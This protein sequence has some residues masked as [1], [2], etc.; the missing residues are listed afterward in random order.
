M[1]AVNAIESAAEKFETQCR[2][3][4]DRCKKVVDD[5]LFAALCFLMLGV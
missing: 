3:T 1:K 4:V 2:T 5:A